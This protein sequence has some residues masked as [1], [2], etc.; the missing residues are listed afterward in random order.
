VS[1][2]LTPDTNAR[3][4]K[5]GKVASF[6]P[7]SFLGSNPRLRTTF[8]GVANRYSSGAQT[9]VFVSSNLTASTRRL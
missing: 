5:F 7:R 6:R 4:D 1:S 9:T 8:A 2:N 3:L